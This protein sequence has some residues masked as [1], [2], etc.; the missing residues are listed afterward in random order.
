MM[1]STGIVV[2]LFHTL[3]IFKLH[4]VMVMLHY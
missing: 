3:W 1:L 4:R 2:H